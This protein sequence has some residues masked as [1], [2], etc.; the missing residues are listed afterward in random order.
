M[1]LNAPMSSG[2]EQT[3][4]E[5]G[6][7]VAGRQRSI[8]VAARIE[9]GGCLR[10]ARVIA[11]EAARHREGPRSHCDELFHDVAWEPQSGAC[12]SILGQGT[13]GRLDSRRIGHPGP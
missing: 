6:L 8:D 2:I 1:T 4:W 5:R 13:Q 10:L 9:D 7:P 3:R 12:R 11:L